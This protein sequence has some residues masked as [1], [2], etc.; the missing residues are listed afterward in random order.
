LVLATASRIETAMEKIVATDRAVGDGAGQG[1]AG[2]PVATAD[3]KHLF[4][5]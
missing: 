3:K 4:P 2:H 5:A 1:R